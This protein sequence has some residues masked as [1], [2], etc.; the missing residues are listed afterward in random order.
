MATSAGPWRAAGTSVVG[1]RRSLLAM[2]LW[3]WTSWSAF[4]STTA[5]S[6][7]ASTTSRRSYISSA[8]V[9][10][11]LRIATQTRARAIPTDAA[12]T[13]HAQTTAWTARANASTD[14]LGS[15]GDSTVQ[16]PS[17][18]SSSLP[19][20]S[21]SGKRSRRACKRTSSPSPP[22]ARA[23]SPPPKSAIHSAAARAA[24]DACAP[25]PLRRALRVR[26][27]PSDRGRLFAP[28]APGVPRARAAPAL[29]SKREKAARARQKRHAPRRA[30]A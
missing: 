2:L 14:G 23:A 29:L 10:T 1:S 8:V 25:H 3:L 20:E 6:A 12:T 4:A 24:R 9:S 11:A 7:A 15:S 17:P 30:C 21:R 28:P 18:S 16:P 27:L 5:W 22:A 19:D 26:G 13:A